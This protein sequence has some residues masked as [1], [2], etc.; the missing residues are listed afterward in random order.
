[1]GIPIQRRI[2]LLTSTSF[3]KH[4][5]TDYHDAPWSMS[6]NDDDE[7]QHEL[8]SRV[9]DDDV[10]DNYDNI[11]SDGAASRRKYGNLTRSASRAS[12]IC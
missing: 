2:V 12:L 5:R 6:D 1:M 4:R 9:S 3:S 7:N 8:D 10:D 11:E